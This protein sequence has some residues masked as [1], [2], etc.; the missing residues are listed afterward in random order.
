MG[1]GKPTGLPMRTV[2]PMVW[3]IF[4]TKLVPFVLL[5]VLVIYV[6]DRLPF[7]FGITLP[8]DIRTLVVIVLLGFGVGKILIP[9]KKECEKHKGSSI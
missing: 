5:S 3:K 4:L 6:M 8:N 2:I 1:V 7:W 9:L